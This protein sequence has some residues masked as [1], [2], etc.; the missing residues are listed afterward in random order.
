MSSV[1]Q[2]PD[3]ETLDRFRAG[4]MDEEPKEKLRLE[5]HLHDCEQ[6]RQRYDWNGA[7]PG[8]LQFP[9][10]EE[11]LKL[12]RQEAMRAARRSVAARLVPVAVAA[13][14]ALVAVLV[15]S[16]LQDGDTDQTRVA[17]TEAQEVPEVYEEL[18][19]YLWLADH[20]G[21]RDSS[22]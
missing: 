14:I 22:T 19:F 1:S 17:G 2:H 11:R 21:T 12:A 16:P 13:A 8:A 4:L 20:K 9:A 7:I 15:V 10:L 6:C 3:I 5:A 18:D